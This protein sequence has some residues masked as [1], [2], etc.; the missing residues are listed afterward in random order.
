[1]AIQGKQRPHQTNRTPA[2]DA[3]AVRAPAGQGYGTNSAAGNPSSI[4]PGQGGPQS[5]L[6]KNMADIAD[7]DGVL[8]QVVSQGLGRHDEGNNE[9]TRKI[10]TKGY[11][12]AF[13]MSRQQASGATKVP[14]KCGWS[15]AVPVRRP[16]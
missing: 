9:Q 3:T 4:R 11:P 5:T 1:M 16:S 2:P 7:A 13:G 12:A 14:P 6:A 8:A 10:D 15:S